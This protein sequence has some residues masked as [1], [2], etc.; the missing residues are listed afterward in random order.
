MR[1]ILTYH[2]IDA[3]PSPISID[4]A[5]F[6]RHVAWL[7]SGRVRVRSLADLLA[8]PV[9]VDAVALTF[10]DGF[11]SF[12]ELA[13][14]ILRDHGLPATVFVVTDH[15]GGVNAWHGQASNRIPTRSLMD[16]NT[17]SR[18]TEAGVSLGSHTRRHRDLR[19]V[20]APELEDELAGSAERIVRETGQRP[21]S[22]AYPYGLFDPTVAMAS[23]RVYLHACTTVLRPLKRGED[24]HRLPRLD[25][26]YFRAPGRLE[27]WGSLGFRRYVRIRATARAVRNVMTDLGR[28]M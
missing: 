12:S 10:D 19:R 6:R 4:E 13:W 1:A 3:A 16:W 5:T 15:V 18:L 24:P 23:A 11:A 14:P 20:T 17:L 21:S 7:G 8:E 2:A 9:D 26:W 28:K 22:C 25:A 27:Q